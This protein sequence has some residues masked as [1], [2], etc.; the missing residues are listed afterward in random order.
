MTPEGK[1]KHRI[2]QLLADFRPYSHAPVQNGMGKPALD[3]NGCHK[4]FYFTIEAKAPGEKATKRQT[5]T[6]REVA[7]AGGCVF[8]IDD[9]GCDDWEALYDWLKDPKAEVIGPQA[10]AA[11]AINI[12]DNK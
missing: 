12:E 4:G 1:V 7:A 9:V 10:Q 5:Q 3:F 6:M 11:M 8:L 2:R